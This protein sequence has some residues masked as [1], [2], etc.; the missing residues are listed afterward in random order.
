[1]SVESPQSLSGGAAAYLELMKRCLTRTL[2]TDE[3]YREV[4]PLRGTLKHTLWTP[5][6]R[7]LAARGYLLAQRVEFD[8]ERAVEG[9][10]WPAHA[11]TMVGFKRLDNI[12]KCVTSVVRHN[13]PGD[14]VEA[15]VWRGGSAIFM[16]AVLEALGDS[17]RRVW[18]ADS[19]EGL[20]KPRPEQ[21]QDA[22]DLHWTF[23]QLAIPLEDVKANFRRYGLLDDRVRFL[24]GWFSETLASAPITEISVLRL[25]GDMYGSTMDVLTALYSRVSAYGYVIIDDYKSH[26]PCAAAVDEFRTTNRIEHPLI[27]VDSAAVYWQCGG[28]GEV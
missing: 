18:A 16:R 14:L 12:Q 4:R 28:S 3:A 7:A 25:D 8:Y 22:G 2:F 27:E 24:P 13:V 6:R 11:D 15:G 23:D 5:V 20:P 10:E 17:D 9:G 26:P 19:F 1:V 21:S